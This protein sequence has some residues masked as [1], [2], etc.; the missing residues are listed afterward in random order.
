MP[1]SET[2]PRRISV[3]AVLSVVSF[4]VA[5]TLS[6]VVGPSLGK[7]YSGSLPAMVTY[8]AWAAAPILAIVALVAIARSNG[9]LLGRLGAGFAL[10][11]STLV[12]GMQ[13]FSMAG[14]HIVFTMDCQ[15]HL[16]GL[17]NALLVYAEDCDGLLPAADQ[18]CDLMIAKADISPTSLVCWDGDAQRAES[19]YAMNAAIAGKKL[20]ELPPD[21][22]V[23]FEVSFDKNEPRE[24]KASSRAF[25]SALDLSS[26]VWEMRKVRASQWNQV[27]GLSMANTSNHPGGCNILFADCSVRF[28]M[29]KQLPLLRWTIDSAPM[30]SPLKT[31]FA[32]Y[33]L[34]HVILAAVGGTVVIFT[35]VVIFRCWT[36]G[37]LLLTAVMAIGSMAAGLVCGGSSELLYAAASGT[38][39][40]L[41]GV[42]YGFLA[43]VC[44]SAYLRSSAMKIESNGDLCLYAVS[45]GMATGII[46]STLVHLTLMLVHQDFHG[47]LPIIAGIPFGVVAGAILGTIAAAIIGRNLKTTAETTNA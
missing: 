32:G 5:V 11:A 26:E 18:W 34:R 24:L 43:G 2:K 29:E 33:E 42:F 7:A 4:L 13:S 39:G 35:L 21:I 41:A 38:A 3:L 10:A 36:R 28:V 16:K 6:L 40:A 12:P 17:A 15:Q 20:S 1:E 30:T 22:V 19:S 37:S 46:A 47:G 45:L 25:V 23:L 27:G 31:T 44:Y 9:R 8:I 14:K